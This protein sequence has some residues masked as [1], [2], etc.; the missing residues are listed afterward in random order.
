MK[1]YGETCPLRMQALLSGASLLKTDSNPV[2]LLDTFCPLT[3]L[4]LSPSDAAQLL[5]ET[6]AGNYLEIIRTP[7]TAILPVLED[8]RNKRYKK[9]YVDRRRSSAATEGGSVGVADGSAAHSDTAG[10]GGSGSP[11]S[12]I[13]GGGSPYALMDPAGGP[14]GLSGS[15]F[16]LSAGWGSPHTLM[17]L[18]ASD[19]YGPAHTLSCGGSSGSIFTASAR[20]HDGS[21][22]PPPPECFGPSG[23]AQHPAGNP[24]CGPGLVPPPLDGS[25]VPAPA[26]EWLADVSLPK[27]RMSR[28]TEPP[29]P[30]PAGSPKR[31]LPPPDDGRVVALALPDPASVPAATRILRRRVTLTRSSLP[32]GPHMGVPCSPS[33]RTHCSFG[34]GFSG[35]T[36][37]STSSRL[38][39]MPRSIS[40]SS[41]LSLLRRSISM[42]LLQ[43][44][45]AI[46]EEGA[47][48]SCPSPSRL[49]NQ[50]P[51]PRRRRY[52]S[53]GGTPVPALSHP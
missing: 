11:R 19:P 45:T 52:Q 48:G 35:Q 24:A 40:T 47:G 43:Q 46:P 17:D 12:G 42:A 50:Q 22:V 25:F 2:C 26:P 21:F 41:Q 32:L 16:T 13:A 31:A 33:V 6:I 49:F 5:L 39:L 36:S 34:G 7:L 53:I 30:K 3:T 44:E 51:L 4:S 38:S 23:L 10:G 9:M 1:T 27:L 29:P 37:A 18:A 14:N 28:L 15:V 8:H 20:R